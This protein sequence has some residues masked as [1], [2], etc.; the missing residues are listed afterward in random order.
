M[1]SLT[2]HIL[3][4]YSYTVLYLLLIVNNPQLQFIKFILA[5]CDANAWDKAI[6]ERVEAQKRVDL[7][8]TCL[9]LVVTK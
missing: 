2:C 7:K 9:Q 3:V 1:H 6:N 4:Q 5:H 8:F